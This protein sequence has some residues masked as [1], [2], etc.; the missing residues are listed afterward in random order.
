MTKEEIFKELEES[1]SCSE[2]FFKMTELLEELYK[3][4]QNSIK[5][6]IVPIIV[7]NYKPEDSGEGYYETGNYDDTFEMGIKT[8]T[9]DILYDIGI[10]LDLDLKE[11]VN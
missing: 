10:A 2:P 5:E 6:I 11:P 1:V 3:A 8:G 4:G 9:R 7:N